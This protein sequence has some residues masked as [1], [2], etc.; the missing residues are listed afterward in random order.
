LRVPAVIRSATLIRAD[1]A[2]PESGATPSLMLAYQE[3]RRRRTALGLA[4][5]V[6]AHGIEGIRRDGCN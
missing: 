4:G 2:R 3:S 6:S 1:L 5:G